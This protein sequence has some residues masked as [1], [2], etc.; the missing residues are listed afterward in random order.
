ME[1]NTR[2]PV[3]GM[4]PLR[5]NDL[6]QYAYCPRI[7]F[8]HYILP[9]TIE[10]TYKMKKG[11]VEQE[12]IERLESRRKFRKYGLERAKRLFH[13]RLFSERLQ[14]SGQLDMLLDTDS[15]LIPV[16]FKNTGKQPYSNH[17]YQLAAYALLLEEAGNGPV[18]TGFIYLIQTNDAVVIELTS[19]LK[20]DTIRQIEKVRSLLANRLLPEATPYRNRCTDCEF[21]N[22]CGDVF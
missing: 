16:D 13:V 8:Y 15:Q 12:R 4:I 5:V 20:E 14:L 11:K 19:S 3:L 2:S 21:R 18:N 1:N 9:V 17:R 22:Y 6:K 7:V 10:E